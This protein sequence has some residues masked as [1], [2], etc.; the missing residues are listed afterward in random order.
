MVL[1]IYFNSNFLQKGGGLK[2]HFNLN[3]TLVII[4]RTSNV[5]DEEIK[6]KLHV[7]FAMYNYANG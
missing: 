2:W 4:E 6:L 5:Q 3:I 7:I 1:N